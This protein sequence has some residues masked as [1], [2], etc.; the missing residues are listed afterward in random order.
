MNLF[1]QVRTHIDNVIA[2]MIASGELSD[3][4]RDLPITVDKIVA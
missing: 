2:A 3:D 4:V 1:Q